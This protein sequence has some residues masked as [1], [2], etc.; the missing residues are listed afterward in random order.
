M[1]I[2]SQKLEECFSTLLM[3]SSPEE[4]GIFPANVDIDKSSNITLIAGPNASGKSLVCKLIATFAREK[5]MACRACSM[6]NRSQGGIES[7][8]IFGDESY[9]STGVNSFGAVKNALISTENDKR[10]IVILDE[11]DIGLSEEYSAAFGKYIADF[12]NSSGESFSHLIVVSHSRLFFNCFLEEYK[13]KVNKVYMSEA[14][15]FD[16]WRSGAVKP[17]NIDELANLSK[18]GR[19][20]FLAINKMA[21]KPD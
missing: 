9:N 3:F 19:D 8:M 1:N 2:V 18:N 15:T 17:A 5:K 13:K 10:G 16:D 20:K 6:L 11:P 12:M 21:E 4:G 14:K 7:A